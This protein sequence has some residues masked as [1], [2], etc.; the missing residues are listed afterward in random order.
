MSTWSEIINN[1]FINNDPNLI[2]VEF[3]WLGFDPNLL[4]TPSITN[5]SSI[6]TRFIRK[7]DVVF[8]ADSMCPDKVANIF[9]DQTNINAYCQKPNKL[10][11][12]ANTDA[13]KFVSNEGI[14]SSSTN[15]FARVISSSDNLLYLNQN[16]ITLNVLA[17][18]ANT[19]GSSDYVEGDLVY[20]T[21]NLTDTTVTFQGKVEFY[22]STNKIIAI[23]PTSGSINTVL[24]AANSVIRKINGSVLSNAASII[25]GNLF[26]VGSTIRSAAN[27]SNTAIVSS[28]AAHEHRSGMFLG[29][30]SSDVLLQSN[31]A[32]SDVT[33]LTFRVTSGSSSGE[34]RTIT[35]VTSNTQIALSSPISGLTSNSRYSIG[36][37]V[38]DEYGKICGI[39]NIP[40]SEDVKFPVGERILTITD[41]ATATDNEYI[42]RAVGAYKVIG[43]PAEPVS[44]PVV[45]TPPSNPVIPAASRRRRRDPLAQTFFTPE[46]NQVI[47][48]LPKPMYGVYIS[49]VDL[50]FSSKPDIDSNQDA[51]PVFVQIVEVVNGLPTEKVLATS[52]VPWRKVNVTSSPNPND[53]TNYTKFKFPDPVYLK[54][55]TEYALVV[56][57]DS[58]EYSVY[59]SELGGNILGTSPPRR[60]SEQPYA[61]S[62]FKSQNASTWTPIQN[63]DL[64]FR[65]NKC[66]FTANQLG[67]AT[68]KPKTQ[69]AN[70][71][72]DSLLF[73][74]AELNHQPTVSRY[75]F[76]SNNVLNVTDATF[77][78]LEPNKLYRFGSDL[79]TSNKTSNR[80]RVVIAGD[81]NSFTAGVELSSSDTDVSPVI[82]LER[83]GLL[84]YEA[85]VNN[86]TF[87]NTDITI[88]NPG[89]HLNA[90]NITITF[91]EPNITGGTRAN[92]YIAGLAPGGQITSSN[93]IIDVVGS[94]YSSNITM[95]IAEAS[96]T[97]NATA[98]VSNELRSVGGNSKA[99]YISKAVT[100]A[101]NFDAGDL[102]VYMDCNRPRGTH[103]EVYCRVKT[104][105]DPQTLADKNWQLMNRV[106]DIY[107]ADQNQI[108][109]LE[110]RP[111][112]ELGTFK[113]FAI[114]IVLLADDSTVPPNV[115]N[116]RAIATPAG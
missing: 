57:S 86:G 15:A 56:L 36:N 23:S 17:F 16:F 27:A 75:K 2:G 54:P 8:D 108:I 19:L 18:G 99:R 107:S 70:V 6:T 116:F 66:V 100:L 98:I 45:I 37:H 14:V 106:S 32:S 24:N 77:T 83:I 68:L 53:S 51:L 110:Y 81:S 104:E 69:S 105:T 39:F 59:V 3:N 55:E 109:E 52:T 94:G 10:T 21:A 115:R 65:I 38:V 49:S 103:I 74:S 28:T 78:Y 47:N 7:N 84:A 112:S 44:P 35:G 95:N 60:V 89:V 42:M 1:S 113:Q 63:Q 92:G 90:A 82:S 13:S 4:N 48:G 5:T 50:W 41:T 12:A 34:S 93:V 11:L 29:Y 102:R 96:A 9:F 67:V 43:R 33:G 87:S 80:R 64:M 22:D 88:T 85:Y 46:A 73:H 62:L 26:P 30:V 20:Q 111:S 72:M 91:S 97:S 58:P 61:G 71:Y 76:K 114:K 101:D 25:R 79:S 31:V 40:E